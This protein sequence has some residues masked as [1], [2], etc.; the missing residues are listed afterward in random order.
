MAWLHG[1]FLAAMLALG[2]GGPNPTPS[3]APALS[4]PGV[5]DVEE[6]A[7]AEQGAVNCFLQCGSD[8]ACRAC[9]ICLNRGGDPATC[10]C[11]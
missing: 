8:Q 11:M 4:D 3:A 2:V 1:L 6:G 9:C 10:P 5:C 7:T